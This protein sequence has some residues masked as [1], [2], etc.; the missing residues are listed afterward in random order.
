MI[1]NGEKYDSAYFVN[2]YPSAYNLTMSNDDQKVIISNLNKAIGNLEEQKEDMAIAMVNID[3]SIVLL[4]DIKNAWGAVNVGTM[5]Q[6]ITASGIYTSQMLAQSTNQLRSHWVD[7]HMSDSYGTV[8]DVSKY[9]GSALVSGATTSQQGDVP[10]VVTMQSELDSDENKV[11]ITE[12]LKSLDKNW[13]NIY[14]NAWKSKSIV[15]ADSARQPA[16][17]TRE[18]IDQMLHKYAPEKEI[19]NATWFV[20]D[21]TSKNGIT[22]IHRIKLIAEKVSNKNL[23]TQFESLANDYGKISTKMS[24]EVHKHDETDYEDS[25][26][27]FHRSESLLSIL[28]RCGEDID[29]I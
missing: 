13:S 21:P 8:W 26:N 24:V 23:A 4:K 16:L 2:S 25:K 27:D 20:P 10:E 14:S 18:L 11:F 5:P 1:G 15:S 6:V 9:I 7:E 28:I 22:R 17:S 19:K 12:R 3:N 29:G